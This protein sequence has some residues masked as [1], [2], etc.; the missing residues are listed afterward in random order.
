VRIDW[1]CDPART[2]SLSQRVFEEVEFVRSTPLSRN[3]VS[4]IRDALQ[5]E[6]EANSQENGYILNQ[7][8]GPTRTATPRRW[9]RRSACRTASAP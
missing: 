9:R 3:Q 2:A 6:F 1:T 4:A 8:Y 5:R 7:I